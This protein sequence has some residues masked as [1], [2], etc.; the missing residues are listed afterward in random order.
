[1]KT[2]NLNLSYFLAR[3][4][5]TILQNISGAR[6][7]EKSYFYSTY[8]GSNSNVMLIILAIFLI[9]VTVSGLDT[10]LSSIIYLREKQLILSIVCSGICSHVAFFA[11]SRE[12]Y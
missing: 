11:V 3:N 9:K 4:N 1:V 5:P 7:T 6:Y 8:K 12:T 10:V 2:E